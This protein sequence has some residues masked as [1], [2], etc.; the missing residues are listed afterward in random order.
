MGKHSVTMGNVEW[1]PGYLEAGAKRNNCS[2]SKTPPLSFLA[3]KGK[4]EKQRLVY[5]SPQGKEGCSL[6]GR[7]AF[8][9][10]LDPNSLYLRGS[11]HYLCNVPRI[12]K[13]L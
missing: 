5:C 2:L 1:W 11:E 7:Q 4:M 9:L 10:A 3:D 13:K 8:S 12:Y 6:L